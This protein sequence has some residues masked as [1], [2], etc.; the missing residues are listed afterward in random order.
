M[1]FS[2]V[3]EEVEGPHD[4]VGA[5]GFITAEVVQLSQDDVDA[6]GVDEPDHHR[7]RHPAE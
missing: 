4:A 2:E 5:L 6:D 1:G 3:E 7:I